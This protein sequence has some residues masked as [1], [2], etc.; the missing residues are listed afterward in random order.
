M[1]P[2]KFELVHQPE[3]R[4]KALG[5]TIPHSVLS[6][7]LIV[8]DRSVIV[9]LVDMHQMPTSRFNGPRLAMLALRPLSVALDVESVEADRA[10]ARRMVE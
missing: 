8:S 1:Q 4:P 7:G 2:T 3:D 6:S 9:R 5:L 10:C